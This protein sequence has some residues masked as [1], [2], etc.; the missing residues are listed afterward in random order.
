LLFYSGGNY[1][2]ISYTAAYDINAEGQVLGAYYSAP[3]VGLI[4]SSFMTAFIRL[5]TTTFYWYNLRVLEHL[6]PTILGDDLGTNWMW[7]KF[8]YNIATGNSQIID[9][10][11]PPSGDQDH[12]YFTSLAQHNRF[13]R[14]SW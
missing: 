3:E 1:A 10:N 7:I 14:N 4:F 9:Y 11:G 12:P 8:I 5:L 6:A 13:R 2:T